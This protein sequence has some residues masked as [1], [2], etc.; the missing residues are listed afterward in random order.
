MS[1]TK[2]FI[3]LRYLLNRINVVV[4]SVILL[5]FFT[6]CTH[7]VTENYS[8]NEA[9]VCSVGLTLASM[10]GD[11]SRV[12]E[13]INYSKNGK[14]RECSIDSKDE[15]GLTALMYAATYGHNNIV[16]ELLKNGAN[17]NLKNKFGA[18]ALMLASGSGYADVVTILLRNGGNPNSADKYG[19]TALMLAACNGYADVVTILLRNGA[20]PNLEGDNNIDALFV[21]KKHNRNNIVKILEA[22]RAKM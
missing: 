13:L 1:I 15:Y 3:S 4:F 21:A 2:M 8:K 5:I 18:T 12:A 16:V 19:M 17:P 7:H 22:A 14:K 6:A 10:Q 20:N 9:Y 11:A